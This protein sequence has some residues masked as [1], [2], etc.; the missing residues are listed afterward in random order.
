MHNGGSAFLYKF[1]RSMK[2]LVSELEPTSLVLIREGS[3]QHRYEIFEGYKAHR[4]VKED[5]PELQE[6][7]KE[8]MA[9]KEQLDEAIGMCLKDL[10]V[11]VLR[12]PKLEADD[13]AASLARW[14]AS[15]GREAVVAST[16]GDF[17]Q[18]LSC[19]RDGISVW[20]PSK[21]AYLSKPDHDPVVR[22]ALQGDKSDG[23][24][25]VPGYGPK[26]AGAA[27]RDLD[28]LADPLASLG[29]DGHAT[30]ERN[31]R[32]IR[33]FEMGDADWKKVEV[34]RGRWDPAALLVDYGYH[35]FGSLVEQ[36]AYDAHCA[37]FG[38]LEAAELPPACR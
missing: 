28:F 13:V 6:K 18:L 5:D 8:L 35:G 10:E 24:P 9:L 31:L 3:P 37:A 33:F 12:H 14:I 27:A 30:Y 11:T 26:R 29:E 22:K 34:S 7:W 20:D 25:G 23:I 15:R 17:E 38:S 2:A 32:L 19:R 1:I 16:D 36:K 4:K 21:K